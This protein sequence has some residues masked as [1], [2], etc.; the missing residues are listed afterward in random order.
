MV[1]AIVVSFM[2]GVID[3]LVVG[4]IVGR[5]VGASVVVVVDSGQSK[6]SGAQSLLL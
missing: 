6:Y 1:G 2:D 5:I 4:R 3:G